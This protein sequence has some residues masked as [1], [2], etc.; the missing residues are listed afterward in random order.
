MAVF[1]TENAQHVEFLRSTTI[2]LAVAV[3]LFPAKTEDVSE[4]EYLREYRDR[5][6]SDW[7]VQM[8]SGLSVP[9]CVSAPVSAEGGDEA[10]KSTVEAQRTRQQAEL[11]EKMQSLMTD[12]QT[13]TSA[14]TE[15]E[16]T[17]VTVEPQSFEKDD[18]ANEHVAFVTSAANLRCFNYS[19]KEVDF[20]E[21]KVIA[22]KIIAAI[23]TTTAAV[24]GLVRA[25][26]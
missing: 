22:G 16:R 14:L 3:G 12:L 21:V 23:A 18:D 26:L 13:A 2:L 7:L 15:G 20:H 10:L 11:A 6:H 19:I 9:E 4:E 25:H 1:S 17:A 5:S 8:V 24:C